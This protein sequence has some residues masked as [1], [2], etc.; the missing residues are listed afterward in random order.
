MSLAKFSIEP[1]TRVSPVLIGGGAGDSQEVRGLLDGQASEEVQLDQLGGLT[2]LM[3]ELGQG[4]IQIDELRRVGQRHGVRL[5]KVH[6]LSVPAAL[7]G[8]LAPGVLD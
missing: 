6:T 8:P 7:F 3:L 1:R 4:V 5:F 2:V